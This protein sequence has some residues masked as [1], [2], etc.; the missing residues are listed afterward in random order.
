M[1]VSFDID[2]LR[3]I[4]RKTAE[5]GRLSAESVQQLLPELGIATQQ[6]A[7]GG[8]VFAGIASPITQAIGVGLHGPVSAEELTRL[9]DFFFLRK[10]D[11]VLELTPYIDDSVLQWVRTRPYGLV[12]FTQVHAVALNDLNIREASI[13]DAINVYI[14]QPDE[15]KVFTS[16]VALGYSDGASVP[17]QDLLLFEGFSRAPGALSFLATV[18]GGPAGGAM[19]SIEGELA[20]LHGGSTLPPFRGSG[21][22]TELIF[23]RLR[24][25]RSRGCKTAYTMT[26]PFASSQRNMARFGFR[27]V[28]TRVK[29]S[30][31]FQGPDGI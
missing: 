20:G 17:Q 4:E 21:V 3:S 26:M 14:V 13:K 29:V 19:L 2:F 18:D 28:Y 24:E 27:P 25:A 6:I 11:V 10:A 15:Y 22:Q 23:A 7:G 30:R 8:A 1:N 31:P 12:E 16:T 5:F 9:E